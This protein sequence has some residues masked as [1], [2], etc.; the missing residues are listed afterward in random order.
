MKK[1]SVLIVDD[2]QTI[3]ET[4]QEYFEYEGHSAIIASN[5]LEALTL[6]K[7]NRPN[8][9]ILDMM[10]PEMN[11]REFRLM[12]LADKKISSIPVFLCTASLGENKITD[13]NFAGEIHKPFDF[14]TLNFKLRDFLSISNSKGKS[15]RNLFKKVKR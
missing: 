5:G 14:K 12:Q 11:G 15:A 13:L 2:D 6:L 7:N 9:I 8:C 4:L 1:T 3:R 10:M